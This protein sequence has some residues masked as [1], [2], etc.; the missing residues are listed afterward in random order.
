MHSLPASM[1][2]T[3]GFLDGADRCIAGRGLSIARTGSGA[4]RILDEARAEFGP[5]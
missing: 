5:V 2:A 1:D 3:H 4:G